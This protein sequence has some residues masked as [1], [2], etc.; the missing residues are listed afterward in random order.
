[1]QYSRLVGGSGIGEVSKVVRGNGIGNDVFKVV[2]GNRIGK[3]V[4]SD[5][6]LIPKSLWRL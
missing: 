1:M 5:K 6:F 2:E 3:D 4:T